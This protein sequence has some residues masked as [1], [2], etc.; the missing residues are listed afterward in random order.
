MS[1]SSFYPA[2]ALPFRNQMPEGPCRG[3]FTIEA[4]YIFA[5]IFFSISAIIR[6]AWVQRN[7]CLAA[8][9]L[10]ESSEKAVRIEEIYDPDGPSLQDI[11]ELLKDR[12]SSI[13]ALK[14]SDMRL[15]SELFHVTGSIENPQMNLSVTKKKFDPENVMR[16]ATSL[17]EFAGKIKEY[18]GGH[19][20][21]GI[22]Q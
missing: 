7:A 6:F 2:A 15:N 1:D 13:G 12:I 17:D 4:A 19:S 16:A 9:V 20:D 22:S 8:Y 21:A 10:T 14:N 5:I 18:K 3:S 11:T